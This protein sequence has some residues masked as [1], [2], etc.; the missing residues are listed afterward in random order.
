MASGMNEALVQLDGNHYQK[1][2][3]NIQHKNQQKLVM[4][5][6]TNKQF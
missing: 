5:C 3:Q 4:H 2:H 6:T 1:Q